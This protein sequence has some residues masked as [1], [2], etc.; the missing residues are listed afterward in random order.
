MSHQ[1][2]TKHD[3]FVF[4]SKV[5]RQKKKGQLGEQ[6]MCILISEIRTE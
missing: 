4:F 6:N 3:K 2:E 1:R 5:V